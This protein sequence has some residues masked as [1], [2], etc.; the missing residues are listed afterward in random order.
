M[1]LELMTLK[2]PSELQCHC[3]VTYVSRLALHGA[4]PGYIARVELDRKFSHSFCFSV[5][6]RHYPVEGA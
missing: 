3:V 6:P 2:C 4:L 1:L 5:T